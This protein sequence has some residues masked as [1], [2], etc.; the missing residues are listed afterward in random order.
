MF[1]CGASY[2]GQSLNEELLQGP[3]L[4]SSLIGATSS[5]SCA[6]FA[7]RKC[8]EDF[9]H[10]Y[11]DETV[12]KLQL[13]F[14]VNDCLVSVVTEEEAL[15][16]CH[17]LISLCAKGGF[18]LT[19]WHSNRSEVLK[20][21]PEPYRAK[22]VRQLDLERE[23]VPIERVLGVEWCIKSDTFKFKIVWKDRPLNRRG[24]LSTVSSIYDPLG[25]L[26]P[27]RV[28]QLDLERE[29]VPIERVLGVE[30]CIK[31]DTFKFK[32]VWKDRPLNRRGILSTV[33]S[34][35]DPLGMLSP[36]VLTA[37]KILRDLCRRGAG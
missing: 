30:W 1:D 9:G 20:A 19:K 12:D 34:I 17:E 23:F 11:K 18:C 26:S 32:I 22:G 36:L 7:L 3:D 29:F 25:M 6:N 28:R 13:C 2:K 16:L 21:I 4:T 37:K 24:I 10:E 8:A 31:S 27:R 14:Y 15:T 33:S 35:Y 5:P